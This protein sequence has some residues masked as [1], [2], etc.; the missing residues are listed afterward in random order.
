[1]KYFCNTP[2]VLKYVMFWKAEEKVKTHKKLVKKSKINLEETI[3]LLLIAY[4]TIQ[5][6]NATECKRWVV[7]SDHQHVLD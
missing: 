6:L 4:Q 5:L 2:M 3:N 7:I 1:M